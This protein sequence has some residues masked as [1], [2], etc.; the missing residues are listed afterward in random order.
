MRWRW[1]QLCTIYFIK[2]PYISYWCHLRIDWKLFNEI[3]GLAVLWVGA[4]LVLEGQL[5]VGQ[6]IAFRIISS[7]LLA[8]LF[9]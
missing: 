2:F 8:L 4:Y 7:M 1:Q 5:T 3:G 6:L 9:D